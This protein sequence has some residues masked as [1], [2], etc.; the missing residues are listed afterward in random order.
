MTLCLYCRLENLKE[1]VG[2]DV[3][4]GWEAGDIKPP[5]DTR[6]MVSPPSPHHLDPRPQWIRPEDYE[7]EQRAKSVLETEGGHRRPEFCES[8]PEEA[9]HY[10]GSGPFSGPNGSPFHEGPPTPHGVHS[11]S[12]ESMMHNGLDGP[13]G[14]GGGASK[15][16]SSRR[17]AWGN[18]SYADLITQVSRRPATTSWGQFRKTLIFPIQAILSSPEKR[19]TLSQVYDWM[20]Q[21]IPYFKDKGDS[22]SSAGWKV[23]VCSIVISHHHHLCRV[24]AQLFFLILTF[25]SS[26]K[27]KKRT[28]DSIPLVCWLVHVT[29][30][31]R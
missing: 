5:W 1:E 17:N 9:E 20:V 8:L 22:N 26:P 19:L 6:K 14:P 10:P 18:L 13:P 15:K 21:N 11:F 4:P 2:V 31:K 3:K 12:P 28:T 16:S 29:A 25:D 27:T 24:S 23:G 7:D 30:L